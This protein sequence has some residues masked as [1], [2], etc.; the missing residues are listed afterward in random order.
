[1][2]TEVAGG[3]GEGVVSHDYLWW[4]PS[5]V[6]GRYLAPWLEGEAAPAGPDPPAGSIDVEIS[7]PQEWHREPMALDP[8][9]PLDID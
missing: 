4:P 9:E 3:G 2:R 8:Y 7:L 6:S 1:M 5:K